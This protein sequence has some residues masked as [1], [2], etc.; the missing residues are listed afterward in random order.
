MNH[1]RAVYRCLQLLKQVPKDKPTTVPTP[2]SRCVRGRTHFLRYRLSFILIGG[3]TTKDAPPCIQTHV[4]SQ[5]MYTVNVRTQS[6]YVLN[7]RTQGT[8][9]R[10]KRPT[11][12][13]CNIS[14]TSHS[15][16]NMRRSSENRLP[17]NLTS[18]NIVWSRYK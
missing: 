4:H 15:T 16:E 11:R 14:R 7:V 8:F 13:L 9:H 2:P 5:C 12:A 18:S 10:T 6:M 17:S 3:L 1:I